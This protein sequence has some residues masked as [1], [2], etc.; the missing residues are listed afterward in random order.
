MTSGV[1]TPGSPA[2]LLR[3][4]VTLEALAKVN[5]G[6]AD[7]RRT[8]AEQHE[9]EA[10]DLRRRAALLQPVQRYCG[11]GSGHSPHNNADDTVC[12]GYPPSTAGSTS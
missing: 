10:A 5:Y 12:G 2:Q 4:A 6:L 3:R 1:W 7:A 11:H 9:R 8:I